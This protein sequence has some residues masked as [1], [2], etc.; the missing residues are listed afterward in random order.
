MKNES[1]FVP[2]RE[3]RRPTG[4]FQSRQQILFGRGRALRFD[5]QG[6]Y[7]GSLI[8]VSNDLRGFRPCYAGGCEAA[9]YQ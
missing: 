6:Y 9:G 5:Y 4:R 3:L 1:V 7:M 2:A 8:N